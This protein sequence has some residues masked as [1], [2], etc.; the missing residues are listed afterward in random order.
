M[1]RSRTPR[2][3]RSRP[4]RVAILGFV[5]LLGLVGWSVSSPA[6]AA[7]PT[8]TILSPANN[9]IIGNGSPVVLIFSVSDFNLTKPGTGGPPDPNEGHVVVFVDGL[10]TTAASAL[11]IELD[12]SSGPHDI[13]LQLVTDNGT[14]LNP[15]VRD[16][17]RVIVTQGPAVGVPNIAIM[18]PTDGSVR[19]TDLLV[20]FRVTNFTL[21]L[22]GGPAGV[23]NEGHIHAI[24]DGAFYQELTN[25]EP[26]HLGLE[27]GPHTIRLQLVDSEHRPLTP[28][29]SA[30]VT[31]TVSPG[32]GRVTD[33]G[34]ALAIA[35]GLLGLGVLGL[36]LVRG[37]RKK[38]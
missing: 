10:R 20:S 24:I 15:D 18:N 35:N 31:F 30:S 12:L 13:G 26:V 27:G 5:L 11:T 2:G 6:R 37:R 19:S 8:L 23:P 32:V 29:V 33:F 9:A 17:I 21:I 25:Y 7:P 36:L 4:S 28:D 34:P 16:E 3:D 38:R 22:P 14:P 1:R